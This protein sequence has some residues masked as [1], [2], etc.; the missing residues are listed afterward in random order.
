MH[1]GDALS[2]SATKR[3][4]PHHVLIRVH[5]AAADLGSDER[6]G[7]TERKVAMAVD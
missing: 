1:D 6:V 4:E 3:V 2:G 5:H 7:E